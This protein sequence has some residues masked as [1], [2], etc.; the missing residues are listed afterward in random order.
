[1][2]VALSAAAGLWAATMA[3]GV[4]DSLRDARPR[5]GYDAVDR[6]ASGVGVLLTLAVATVFL[7]AGGASQIARALADPAL[8]FEQPLVAAVASVARGIEIAVA[9]AA[10]IAVTA[11]LLD[12]V[13]GIASRSAL[14]VSLLGFWPPVRAV[15][16]LATTAVFLSAMAEALAEWTVRSLPSG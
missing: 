12:V 16:L 6:L 14:P 13:A 9:V 11:I 1:L 8:A 2:P 15:A 10:P 3:G 4:A 5:P 7:Q